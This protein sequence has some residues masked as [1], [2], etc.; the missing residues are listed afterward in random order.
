MSL[1]EQ[2]TGPPLATPGSQALVTALGCLLLAAAGAKAYGFAFDP[3]S[4]DSFLASPRLQIAEIEIEALLGVWLLSGWGRRAAWGAALALFGILACV[5][6][7]LALAGQPSCGCFGR[8]T[9]NPWVT[10]TLDVLIVAALS[11]WRPVGAEAVRPG[12]GCEGSVRRRSGR[13]PFWSSSVG[14]SCSRSTIP[15][16]RWPGSGVNPLRPNRSSATWATA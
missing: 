6:C 1:H 8:V 14:P 11:Y 15:A 2:R 7:Y 16:A 5:S 3:L 12:S 10:F 13:S 9:I 4:Q